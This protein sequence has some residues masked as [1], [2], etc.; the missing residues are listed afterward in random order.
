MAPHLPT[1][2]RMLL[3]EEIQPQKV[4]ILL[5]A[6]IEAWVVYPNKAPFVA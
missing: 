4:C 2:T 3:F 6:P 5:H 1:P